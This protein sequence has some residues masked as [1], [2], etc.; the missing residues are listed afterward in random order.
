MFD[1]FEMLAGLGSALAVWLAPINI[2][3]GLVLVAAFAADRLLERRVQAAWR[4]A[5]FAAV[6]I[7]LFLP[8]GWQSPLGWLSWR[9]A[10]VVTGGD[11]EVQIATVTGATPA[12]DTWSALLGGAYVLV[13]LVLLGRWLTSRWFLR[14]ALQTTHPAPPALVSRA[15]GCRVEVHSTLGPLV[16]GALRP[17]IVI[18]ESL[19][20]SP[21]QAT[22]DS[23]LKHEIAHVRRRDG[24]LL[25]IVDLLSIA[26]WPVVPVWIAA[27]RIRV[28][29]ET[30]CDER[31]LVDADGRQRRRYAE[32]LLALADPDA[33]GLAFGSHVGNRIRALR[34][35][36]RWPA[37]AQLGCASGLV[38]ALVACSGAPTGEPTRGAPE[39]RAA[40][41]TEKDPTQRDPNASAGSP[42]KLVEQSEVMSGAASVRGS[43]DKEIIRRIIRR[44]INE[45]KHCYEQE[46]AREPRL[47]GRIS[48]Q[49]TIAETGMVVASVLQSST[50]GNPRVESCVVKSVRRWEFPRP[51]DDGVVIVTYP[52]NFTPA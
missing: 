43:L 34:W 29:V 15:G 12:G 49:F 45:V 11:P 23:M 48:V 33:A 50:M 28:L 32:T 31:A 6:G 25:M 8:I 21:D 20:W 7:R 46:L 14:L 2:W 5:L 4:V 19:L 26:F 38:V 35:R 24:L 1:P 9:A 40:S 41:P 3:T 47:A 16:A 18:P 39:P 13:A 44:H 27:R 51:S 37:W 17:R 52:F 30:A 36:K 22:L 10:G 42:S